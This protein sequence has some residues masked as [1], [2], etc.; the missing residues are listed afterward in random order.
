MIEGLKVT[1]G[2]E[3]LAALARKQAD[4]HRSRGAFYA[5][6]AEALKGVPGNGPGY[7]GG[8][9]HEQMVSKMKEHENAA[10]E[11][12]FTAGHLKPAEE[13]LLGHQDLMRL[14]IVRNARNFF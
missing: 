8:D 10:M 5:T 4:Y 7:S 14:G 12:D 11:L 1:V 13:Y 3:E 9:P 2:G 6:K